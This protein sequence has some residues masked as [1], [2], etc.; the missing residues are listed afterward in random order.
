[1]GLFDESIA[2]YER[3]AGKF[4]DSHP[5]IAKL[6]R[7]AAENARGANETLERAEA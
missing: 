5:R 7:D 6:L 1:M 4:E 3:A 2:E